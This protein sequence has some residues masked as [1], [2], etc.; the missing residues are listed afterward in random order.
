M[1]F[2]P[3]QV[4][5]RYT[6]ASDDLNDVNDTS[7]ASEGLWHPDRSAPIVIDTNTEPNLLSW[8]AEPG[9]GVVMFFNR[10]TGNDLTR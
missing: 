10:Y 6:I 8:A 2:N 3:E 9:I 5:A 1:I 4:P 7:S